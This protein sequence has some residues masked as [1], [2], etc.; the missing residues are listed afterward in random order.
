M[1]E[2]EEYA[3]AGAQHGASRSGL[4]SERRQMAGGGREQGTYP[5][6]EPRERSNVVL[7]KGT[8]G[9]RTSLHD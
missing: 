7:V 5:A 4:W 8:V 2:A 3:G 1:V 9:G 6:R